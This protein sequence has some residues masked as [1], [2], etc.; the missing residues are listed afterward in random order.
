MTSLLLLGVFFKIGMFGFGGGMAT[1]PLVFQTVDEHSWMGLNEFANLVAISQ[2]SPGPVM[3][4][5]A[6]YVGYNLDGILGA[7]LATIGVIIPSFI[8]TLIAMKLLKKYEK[9]TVVRGALNG[10]RPVSIGLIAATV[11]FMLKS[12]NIDWISGLIFLSTVVMSLKFKINPMLIILIMA[13]VGAFVY[14]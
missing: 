13:F 11:M 7:L 3:V 5:A 12:V 14:I 6:T 9:T 10:L 2:I 1:L 4:N 8:F